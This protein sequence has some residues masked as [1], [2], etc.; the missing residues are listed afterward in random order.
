[1][2][3]K[4]VKYRWLRISK[5]K[6]RIYNESFF[7]Y[8]IT[9]PFI[10]LSRSSYMYQIFVYPFVDILC[11]FVCVCIIF[12]INGSIFIL[13]FLLRGNS[14]WYLN[15]FSFHFMAAQCYTL[16]LYRNLCIV[17]Y[18]WLS[19]LFLTFCCSRQCCSRQYHTCGC[20]GLSSC[21]I[22]TYLLWGA[23]LDQ[24]VEHETLDFR[25]VSLSPMVGIEIT[26]KKICFQF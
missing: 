26:L 25:V 14:C 10:L 6:E 21:W 12:N 5:G 18:Q 20:K 1:M 24:L 23:W 2:F 3:F 8:F 15:N 9:Q 19:R 16:Q 13:F 22:K 17:P 4:Q 7:F 11:V